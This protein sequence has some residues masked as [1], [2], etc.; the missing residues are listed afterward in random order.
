MD[1]FEES[2]LE[3]QARRF[4]RE[5]PTANPGLP[6]EKFPQRAKNDAYW[7]LRLQ[8]YPDASARRAFRDKPPTITERTVS[9][10]HGEYEP[11]EIL[12]VAGTKYREIHVEVRPELSEESIQT[13]KPRDF[14]YTV[15]DSQVHRFGVR[16]RPSG[17]MTY[18]INYRI[19]H[20]KRLHKY[21]IGRV[22]D[23]PL[24]FAR[25]VA[26][27]IRRHA[28]MGVDPLAR[29]RAQAENPVDE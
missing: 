24:E 11:D 1:E 26:R 6:V 25:S 19:R 2:T 15:W 5:Y 22:D 9:A 28:R 13:L 16:V 4:M 17:H 7:A 23:F 8:G 14:E 3:Q 21:T 20:Q 27:D 29:L 18:I 10:D 12:F